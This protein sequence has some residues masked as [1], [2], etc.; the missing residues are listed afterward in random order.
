[1]NVDTIGIDPQR[2]SVHG[3]GRHAGSSPARLLA[4]LALAATVFAGALLTGSGV[5]GAHGDTGEI[6][7][8][9]AE[10]IG[11][12]RIDLEVGIVHG[13]DGHI[14]T[15]ATVSATLVGPAGDTVGPVPLAQVDPESSLYAAQ[16][17]VSGPGSWAVA[18]D[19]TNPSGGLQ[20]DVDVVQS[21]DAT[22][23]EGSGAE[24]TTSTAAPATTEVPVDGAD[25]AAETP[26]D[27]VAD[28]DSGGDS[29]WL[30]VGAALA[31]VALVAIVTL[32]LR[33]NSG[34]EP[35]DDALA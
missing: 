13:D 19:S 9:R 1:M 22:P 8:T 35:D 29:Q 30:L 15:E 14:A 7:V 26:V 28:D 4:R 32:A 27:A 2:A 23:P 6:T 24:A 20:T 18:I 12:N 17:E 11:P 16:I 21:T 25:S 31:A 3:R 34:E 5:A 10:Q 33:R